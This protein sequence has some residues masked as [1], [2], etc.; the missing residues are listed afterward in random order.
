MTTDMAIDR[1]LNALVSKGKRAKPN[2]KGGF[3]VQ[4][5]AHADKSP[6][7]ELD[8]GDKGV[9][10][11]CHAGCT[12]E[13][14]VTALG[15][16]MDDLFDVPLDKDSKP[17]IPR[18]NVDG[19]EATYYYEN[20][21]GG[22]L[23][24]VAKFR[25]KDGGKRFFQSRPNPQN[26]SGPWLPN[27]ADVQ[28]VPF[29]LPEVVG[30]VRN[31]EVVYIVEGE[32]D[33][34]TLNVQGVVATC[35]S[36]GAGKWQRS[37]SQFFMGATVVIIPDNDKA[38]V[39]HA[40]HVAETLK[41]AAR[42]I[43]VVELPGLADKQDVT[44]WLGQ[45]NTIGD[46]EALVAATPPRFENRPKV[47]TAHDLMGE[48]FPDVVM[49]VPGVIAEG[50]T[51]MVGAPKI[52]KSWL[53]LGIAYAISTGNNALGTIPVVQGEVLYMAL[54]DTPRRLQR[55]LNVLAGIGTPAPTTMHFACTWPTMDAGG[56]EDLE[57]WLLDHP[58][59]RL[60]IIDTWA[61]FKPKQGSD[62]SSMYAAD[63]A[64]ISGVK[65]LA[66]T[67]GVPIVLIHHQR[68]AAD[69]DA[70]NTVAGSTGLTGA[71]DATCVLTRERGTDNGK[72]YVT[73][74]DVEEMTA[75]LSFDGNTGSWLYLGNAEDVEDSSMAT[76]IIAI[77]ADANEDSTVDSVCEALN[78]QL[79]S[80]GTAVNKNTVKYHLATLTE[81]KKIWRRRRGHYCS[82]EQAYIDNLTPAPVGWVPGQAPKLVGNAPK[83]TNQPTSPKVSPTSV[84]PPIPGTG[85]T[86]Q[87]MGP[88]AMDDDTDLDQ[89]LRDL[90]DGVEPDEAAGE[91]D[92]E[93][94]FG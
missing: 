58:A 49:A 85:G 28:R 12:T 73:G 56:I 74:R 6:S 18:P 54:E 75:A 15:L 44:D 53:S 77:I 33:V 71:A 17:Q 60:V 65:Q 87:P 79:G 34:Y 24:R 88:M 22:V 9:I 45:G 4:C 83:G 63:Y 13:E 81:E 23:Y 27:M 40:K 25:D 41:D 76:K 50:V 52:G 7:M 78:V 3:K 38:G 47:F 59:C 19:A 43:T 39:D 67:Y 31:D 70:L 11:T 1:V 92:D 21:Q 62:S 16:E 61:K 93:E 57:A 80:G 8:P 82:L 84:Q 89:E 68:K 42:K 72:L 20:E 69:G 64:A 5:P 46:L 36:G 86:P 29:K 26:P 48:T 10:I 90:L 32:K 51:L 55:R 2:G 66:D 37:F 35:N 14:I 91:A 94:D 30:A